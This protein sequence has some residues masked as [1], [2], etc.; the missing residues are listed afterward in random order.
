MSFT[1]NGVTMG[2]AFSV[3][4]S[5]LEGKVFFPHVYM[6]NLALECNFGSKVRFMMH[7]IVRGGSPFI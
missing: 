7:K 5:Q 1:K 3:E 6:K 2:E 4:K